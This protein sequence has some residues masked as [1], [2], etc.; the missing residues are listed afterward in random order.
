MRGLVFLIRQQQYP[1]Y[2]PLTGMTGFFSQKAPYL[3]PLYI[4]HTFPIILLKE[5]CLFP[6]QI[7][8]EYLQCARP[9]LGAE[10]KVMNGIDTRLYS[11][12]K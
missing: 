1:S 8:T 4:P 3:A 7:F 11:P 10:F 6:Q 2:E 5:L 9:M 12:K